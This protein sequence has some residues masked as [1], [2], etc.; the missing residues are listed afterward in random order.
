[1][2][3]FDEDVLNAYLEKELE[4]YSGPMRV[5][6][7]EGGQSNPTFLLTTANKRYV[8]RKKPPGNLLPSAHAVD[9]E[10]RVIDALYKQN[11]P[12]PEAYALCEDPN[13][14]GTM[15][16]VMEKV[17]GRIF[18]SRDGDSRGWNHAGNNIR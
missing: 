11:F 10:H 4:E 1:M 2:H 5:Q 15:F 9:R 16:Y 6:Q 12:V 17:D 13:V 7:F 8:L 14:I 18:C 3:R